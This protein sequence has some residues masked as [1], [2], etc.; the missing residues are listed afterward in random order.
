MAPSG[1]ETVPSGQWWGTA[2]TASHSSRDT[3]GALELHPAGGA[4]V[5]GG[6]WRRGS[7]G[8]TWTIPGLGPAKGKT[9]DVGQPA[10]GTFRGSV[11]PSAMEG[12][13]PSA[14]QENPRHRNQVDD[15]QSTVTNHAPELPKSGAPTRGAQLSSLGRQG[16]A[17]HRFPSLAS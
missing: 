14:C 15:R 4:W 17:P 8:Q 12:T 10:P 6:H 2:T 5:F 13:W 7:Q 3:S 11:V 9:P 16:T 1:F